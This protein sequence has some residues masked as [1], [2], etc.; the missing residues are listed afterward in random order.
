MTAIESTSGRR[1]ASTRTEAPDRSVGAWMRGNLTTQGYCL[2]DDESRE[3]SI[4][5]RF[6][7]GTCL[8]L[9]VAALALESPAMVFVL[10]TV[11]LVAGFTARHPFD[12]LWNR[13]VRHASRA[14]KLLMAVASRTASPIVELAGY[15]KCLLALI[16]SQGTARGSAI[17]GMLAANGDFATR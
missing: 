3:L 5:L 12:H 10:S 16:V 17:Q 4:A 6:S 15:G 13:A 2:T 14:G 9:V 1:L 7:T 11:G 8:L